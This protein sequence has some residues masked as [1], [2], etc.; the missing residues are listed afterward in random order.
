MIAPSSRR[1]DDLWAS[2][3]RS[4]GASPDDFYVPDDIESWR[5][6]FDFD[7]ALLLASESGV[8]DLQRLMDRLEV[9][10]Y[11]RLSRPPSGSDRRSGCS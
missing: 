4:R 3:N 10:S 9:T 2:R 1:G 6:D 11:R 7:T 5:F 8:F